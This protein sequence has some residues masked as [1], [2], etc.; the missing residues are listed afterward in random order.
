MLVLCWYFRLYPIHFYILKGL[1]CNILV[2]SQSSSE[3]ENN[4]SFLSV[5]KLQS[6][7]G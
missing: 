1:D 7:N 5:L 4:F 2:V 6:P 3:S